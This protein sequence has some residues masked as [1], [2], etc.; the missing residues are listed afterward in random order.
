M[1][2]IPNWKQKKEKE[3]AKKNISVKNFSAKDFEKMEQME[4]DFWN[5]QDKANAVRKKMDAFIKN[6][7]KENTP[8]ET[9]EN[10]EENSKGSSNSNNSDLKNQLEKMGMKNIKV[11]QI[12]GGKFGGPDKWMQLLLGG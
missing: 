8:D 5:A 6:K 11:I 12:G 1:P 9:D 7:E 4:S 3:N 10:S 2:T